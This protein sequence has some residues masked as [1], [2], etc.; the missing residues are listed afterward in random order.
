MRLVLDA[1]SKGGSAHHMTAAW[2]GSGRLAFEDDEHGLHVSVGISLAWEGTDDYGTIHQW[3][4]A[5]D[6]YRLGELL[7]V[8]IEN[9]DWLHLDLTVH[10]REYRVSDDGGRTWRIEPSFDGERLAGA[11]S[12]S[13]VGII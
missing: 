1:L 2:G 5:A 3:G 4:D 11:A 12:L 7:V 10:A 8:R 6:L 13:N 9:R